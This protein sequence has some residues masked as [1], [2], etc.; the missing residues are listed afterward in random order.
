MPSEPAPRR[1]VTTRWTL[2]LAA[3]SDPSA[4][5]ARDAL[6]DLCR[7]YWYPVYS[8][9]RRSGHSS[10][11]A[12]DLTQAFFTR[13][14]EK[15][16][17]DQA[18]PDRGRFRSFVLASVRNFLANEYD[19]G[20]SQK[21]G[22]GAS[23]IS[24]DTGDFDQRYAR[25]P[26]EALTPETIYERTWARAVVATA[27]ERLDAAHTREPGQST[28]LHLRPFLTSDEATACHNVAE[29]LGMSDGAVRVA[30][31]RLR[32]QFGRCLREVVGESVADPA[33]AD[34]EL[35][36]LLRTVT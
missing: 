36:H 32:Q 31:H 34:D 9:I 23:V 18:H 35:R 25:E 33:E 13:V 19:R 26:A 11:D 24:L 2:V 16:A 29:R 28:Y 27:L 20:I 3:A 10:D 14:I 17:F 30:L 12:A 21:R 6:A 15:R 22:G 7:K 8:F 5:H 4:T 1:F